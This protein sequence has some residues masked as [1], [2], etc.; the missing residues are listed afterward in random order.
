MECCEGAGIVYLENGDVEYC[1]C[2]EGKRAEKA[3]MMKVLPVVWEDSSVMGSFKKVQ[4]SVERLQKT[5]NEPLPFSMF[6]IRKML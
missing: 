4:E 5:I 2:S 3:G 1:N 6:D